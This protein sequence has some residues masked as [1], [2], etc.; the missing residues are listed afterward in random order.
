MVSE[1]T[2]HIQQ[3]PLPN[4]VK[5]EIDGVVHYS[6]DDLFDAV[7]VRIAF[8]GKHS[9]AKSDWDLDLARENGIVWGYSM[10]NRD[11]LIA[12]LTKDTAG[13]VQIFN[14][15]QVHGSEIYVVKDNYLPREDIEA[16]A[17]ICPVKNVAG[18]LLFAD[19]CPVILVGNNGIFAVVHA[20][21]RGVVNLISKSAFVSLVENFGC[22]PTQINAYVGPHIGACCFEV[23]DD[24]KDKF[25]EIFGQSVINERGGKTNVDLSKAL[26]LQL[27]ESGLSEDRFVDINICTC[28]NHDDYFSYRKGDEKRG[29]QGAIAFRC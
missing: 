5:K 1:K 9:G 27:V 10:K 24:V 8:S 3:P 12:A 22:D 20:G 13:F 2:K 16:D 25:V 29:R 23:S 26:K 11:K 15:R 6:D 18:L 17:V 4:L 28:C 14:P 7:N 19:C 21:W